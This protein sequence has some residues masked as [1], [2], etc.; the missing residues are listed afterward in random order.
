MEIN[1][2]V[3]ALKRQTNPNWSALFVRVDNKPS[4]ANL[5]NTLLSFADPRLQLFTQATV[6][7]VNGALLTSLF[8]VPLACIMLRAYVPPLMYAFTPPS[9]QYHY[10]DAGYQAVD[11]ALHQLL[12]RKECQWISVTTSNNAYGSEVGRFSITIRSTD[13]VTFGLVS[14]SACNAPRLT[15][16]VVERILSVG[17]PGMTTT[18]SLL[19]TPMDSR[20]FLEQGS[21]FHLGDLLARG[22]GAPLTTANRWHLTELYSPAYCADLHYNRKLAPLGII[23][24][25]YCSF[26]PSL[27]QSG[28]TNAFRPTPVVGRVDLASAFFSADLLGKEAVAFGEF[29]LS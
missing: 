22:G 19:L 11:A 2:F 15:W 21:S 1:S 13:A 4:E 17:A 29:G 6:S 23:Q 10:D 20:R 25:D 7:P 24:E 9:E 18:P 8:Q 5:R 14:L 27:E 28:F 26:L 16:Q 12:Q 3:A